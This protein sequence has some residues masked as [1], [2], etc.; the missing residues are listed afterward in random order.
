L[1][2]IDKKTP[3]S[4]P[5]AII[6]M[7]C[8]FP[9]S[10]GLKEYWRLLFHGEDAITDVPETHWLSEDYYDTDPKKP[11]HVYCKRGGFISPVSFD[12]TEFGIPPSCLEATDTSQLLSLIVAQ[13][14]LENSGYGAGKKFN[15]DKTSVILGV[16]GTQ[17][18]VI[19]LGARLGH[20]IWRRALQDSGIKP[21]KTE[22]V[23]QKISDSY[24]SWQENSFPG[25]LG[26]VVAGRI[27]N[28]LDLGGTNCVIDAAC[29]SS[30]SAIHLAVMELIS[31]RSDMV[32][33]GGVDMLNDIFMHM[34]FSKTFVLSPT[35]D[36]RPFSKNAD[37]VVLGEGIGM[38]VLK[39]LDDAEKDGNKIYAVIK[40]VGTSSDGKSQ[41]IYA[42][43]AGGQEKALQTA[44]T[45]AGIDPVTVELIEAHGTGTIVGDEVEFQALNNFFG[46]SDNHDKRCALGSV[47][48]MIGHTKAAAGA[49]GLMKAALSIYNKVLPP[50]LKVDEPDPKLNIHQSPFYLN[51]NTRPWF[52]NNEHPRRAGISSFGFGG[53]NFHVVVEE[54]RRH[55][56]EI[57]WHGSVEILALSASSREQLKEQF[58]DFKTHVDKGLSYEELS[59]KSAKTRADFS[60]SDPYRLLMVLE[61]STD[62]IA[63]LDRASHALESNRSRHT[64]QL[65]NIFYGSRESSGKIAFIFP[66]QGSQYPKMG[67]DLIC[68]FPEAFRILENANDQYKNYGRLTDMIYPI[69]DHGEK[70]TA[71]PEQALRKTDIAQ[72]AIGAV[73]MAMLNILHGFGITADFT[74]GHSFG[75]LSAL[76]AAGSMDLDTLLHLAI[77]RGRLMAAAGQN[78]GGMLAVI[79]PLDKLEHLIA[80]TKPGVIIANRNSP[81]QGVLSGPTDAINQAEKL[82][83]ENGFKTILLPVSAA[84]HSS[85]VKEAQK[86]FSQAIEK[87]GLVPSKIPVFSNT[88][89][90]PY[91]ADAEKA[92]ELLHGHL[93]SPV[94]FISEIK[95]LFKSGARTFVEVGPKSVLTGLVKSIL[96]AQ[97]FQAIAL[98]ASQGKRSGITDLAGTL[99]H[100]A[101]LGHFVD[102]SCW[103]EPYTETRKQ[104]MSIPISGVNY[105]AQGSEVRSRKSEVRGQKSEVRTQKSEVR[106]QKSEVGSQRSEVNTQG[107]EVRSQNTAHELP[108]IE[109]K[110][111]PINASN[112]P[113]DT[114]KTHGYHSGKLDEKQDAMKN[115]PYPKTFI[116]DALNI[117]QEGLK[118]MQAIQMQT[119]QTHQ[120][121]LETQAQAARTLQNMME[122]TQRLA[123]ASMGIKTEIKPSEVRFEPLTQQPPESGEPLTGFDH[124]DPDPNI[125]DTQP[126]LHSGPDPISAPVP[127]DPQPPE[128]FVQEPQ[129]TVADK[130]LKPSGTAQEQIE[131]RMLETVSRL[132]GYPTEMLGL[133]MDIESD[134]GIDSIK[135]VEILST[136]EEQ[137]PNL[138]AISPEIM[139]SLK[140]LGQIVE[141]L[142]ATPDSEVLPVPET[143]DSESSTINH[144]ELE[145]RMLETVSRLTGYPTEMLGMDMDIESDL[146][147]DSIKRVEILS[148]V[149]EQIP[150]LPAISPEIMGSLKTLGQIV[151]YLAGAETA[152]I[153]ES[154]G[155]SASSASHTETVQESS[156]P[157][158][159]KES[160]GSPQHLAAQIHRKVVSVVEQPF[161]QNIP[162][163]LPADRTVYITDDETGLSE[164]VYHEFSSRN[165]HAVLLTKQMV[166]DMVASQTSVKT[167]AGL[168]IVAENQMQEERFLKHSFVLAKQFGPDL[169]D[170]GETHGALFATITRLDGAFGFKGRGM[171]APLQGGLAG[172]AKTASLEWE[173]VCCRAMDIDPD[174]KENTGIATAVVA[175]LL[176]SNGNSPVEVGLDSDSR[177]VFALTDSPYPQGEINLDPGDVVVITGGARG[178]TASAA[179]ALAKHAKPTLV[180]MGRSPDPTPEPEW[181]AQLHNE[182]VVKKAILENEFG[183][184]NITPVDLEKAYKKH[185]ANR[186]IITTL[187]T[188]KSFGA[189]VRYFSADVRD[190]DTVTSILNDVRSEYGPVKG[191]IHGAGTLQDR[192]I[193]DKTLDQFE[194]VFHTKVTGLNVLLEATRQDPLKY[195]V[196][197]SSIT[198]RIGNN[199]QADYAMANEVLNKIAQQESVT[200]PDCKVTAINWGPW[201][202]GMVCSAL[203]RKFEKNGVE[204]IPLDAGALCMIHEMMGHAGAPVE[205]VIG[206]NII[207]ATEH[208]AAES[209]C[210]TLDQPVDVKQKEILSLTVKRE[211]DVHTYPILDAHILDG[212]PV[213]PF[214]LIAEWLGHGA[215]HENPGL[216]LHGLDDMRIF[217]GIKLDQKKKLIRLMA[218][219]TR[220]KGSNF[221]VTVEIRDGIKD[222]MDII[223]SSARAI[224]TDKIQA[225]PS[226]DKSRY[227]GINGYSRSI[228][229]I[230]EKILFHGLELRGIRE[231][232]GYS[233]RSVAARISSAPSPAKWMTDPLR[234]RWIADPLVLDCAC[235]MAIIWCF[236]ERKTLSLPSYS[237]SY[238]QYRDA[239]PTDGVTAVLEVKEVTDHKMTGDFTFLDSED[240]VVARLT[241]YEAVMDASLFKAFKSNRAA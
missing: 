26:N 5:V 74:C 34:C 146:G 57:T 113:G 142:S 227:M 129:L 96:N 201:A 13:K 46:T 219:K 97:D 137:I 156:E 2:N 20:P 99:C 152:Q 241:G 223:H 155:S 188:I 105:R 224:L 230:Y 216:L 184:T 121:F 120:K 82:C 171:N 66:G 134:L 44:Y 19:P 6:G 14:A 211:I 122:N 81:S 16:T 204:L 18:L 77:T 123:A 21:V 166:S 118:S 111:I 58:G 54:Y 232:I 29:A 176:N 116:P 89:G 205:V 169:L 131:T 71:P 106:A 186:E 85:S 197:F 206:A 165:I 62:L 183:N 157:L 28:R 133:D 139:G 30:M 114:L 164:A 4:L 151:E 52:S 237:A 3:Q 22:E 198:A 229:E 163:E 222:N 79:G 175:E 236:E 141:Y 125:T 100:L 212:K 17:E 200:R 42:P 178:V 31:G 84:F 215:L 49:A 135:R 88:T 138:P 32:I 189:Q 112:P 38:F 23:I 149:E 83:R 104:R 45:Q 130:D 196:L 154:D 218:G 217:Q 15:R 147:I 235:Q 11:D 7:G 95:N 92:K 167:A 174:W 126:A 12:P 90:A 136:L 59:K 180:L 56:Q 160:E 63:L 221:E 78:T 27:C 199:G 228:D 231:I 70:E 61:P 39:R 168:I 1:N 67:R 115:K 10:P 195:L 234:S 110:N 190:V 36:S 87:I 51:T 233:P 208:H 148:T 239:F 192:T 53:S 209:M 187:D 93:L 107:R 108:A 75:E 101:S 207:A 103:E 80:E 68:S 117:V 210:S 94:D 177:C 225:P 64:W 158:S 35:G 153:P 98:D 179:C 109:P 25:L 8:L 86:P 124:T 161:V 203:K 238:R 127:C 185:M 193:I 91:P 24:V 182:A 9:K 150:N 213:V 173:N 55:K 145:T 41:S 140:T 202:G 226:F 191:I 240:V 172:L 159:P 48:S 102:L 65:E 33:T 47:K 60:T 143:K 72:P 214:A 37:G 76:C 43:R 162:L 119:A 144:Q 128:A 132:T 40:G 194:T 69:P 73:S 181:L 50:T 220:K 170:S